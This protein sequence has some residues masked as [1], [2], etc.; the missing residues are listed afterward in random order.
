MVPGQLKIPPHDLTGSS[1]LT[2]RHLR[3]EPFAAAGNLVEGE[4]GAVALRM[5]AHR[6]PKH[7]I[8]EKIINPHFPAPLRF[9]HHEDNRGV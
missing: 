2:G 7:I 6:L 1:G 4:A 8:A 5:S 9:R 3:Q